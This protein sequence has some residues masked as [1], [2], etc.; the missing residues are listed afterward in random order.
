MKEVIIEMI[1]LLPGVVEYS[2]LIE[3]THERRR[4]KD[5]CSTVES[6]FYLLSLVRHLHA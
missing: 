6:I 5:R 4:T 3:L 1:G 2:Q